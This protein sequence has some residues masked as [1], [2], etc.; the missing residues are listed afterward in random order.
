MTSNEIRS[1]AMFGRAVPAG[2]WQTVGQH[3]ESSTVAYYV[4]QGDLYHAQ[5]WLTEAVADVAQEMGEEE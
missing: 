5:L 2:F 3:P 1:N 4:A